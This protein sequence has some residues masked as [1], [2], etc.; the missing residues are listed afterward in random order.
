M[1]RALT[2]ALLIA[3]STSAGVWA[4]EKTA[5]QMTIQR[6]GEQAS[7][8][9]PEQLFTGAARIDPLF[10]G[11]HQK[12]ASAA[13]VTFEPGARSNWHTHPGGQFLVVTS[14]VG[15]VQQEGRNI[16]VIKP[17]DLVWTP[18]GVRHWHGASDSVGMTHMAIQFYAEGE[19]VDWQEAVTDAQYQ[20]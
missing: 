17:G 15:W 14:G 2:T 12:N 18:P 7:M 13:Y 1:K 6:N 16:E 3:L 4:E 10:G 20:H 8:T 11:E 19:V 5:A 9:G